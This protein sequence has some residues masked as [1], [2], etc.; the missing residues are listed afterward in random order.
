MREV[1][2]PARY[3]SERVF[4]GERND[5]GGHMCGTPPSTLENGKWWCW[6]HTSAGQERQERISDERVDAYLTDSRRRAEVYAE[7]IRRYH[8]YPKLL[9]ALEEIIEARDAYHGG[10]LTRAVDKARPI[11][12]SAREKGAAK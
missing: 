2:R 12:K 9:K 11:V 6:R 8:L 1:K 7:Q 10:D 3:C 5:T 4:S